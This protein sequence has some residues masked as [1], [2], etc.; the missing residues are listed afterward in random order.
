LPV[1]VERTVV[2]GLTEDQIIRARVV[3]RFIVI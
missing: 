2:L 3:W 1:D